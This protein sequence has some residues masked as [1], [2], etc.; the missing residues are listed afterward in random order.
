MNEKARYYIRKLEL[1]KHPEGGYYREVY[2]AGEMFSIDPPK[3]HLKRNASTSIYFMLEGTQKSKFHRLKS[4]ELWHF[5]DGTSVKIYVID[6]KGYLSESIL[7]KAT[8]QGEVFQT[9]IKKNN[10]FAAEVLN[11]RSFSL[12]GCTV[13]PGF[14]FSDFELADREYLL[15]SFPNHKKLILEFTKS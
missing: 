10:W 7:G 13:S 11:K 3:K 4:D 15:E 12:I 2:R 6:E 8:E 14:D 1:K 5:Y 9:V